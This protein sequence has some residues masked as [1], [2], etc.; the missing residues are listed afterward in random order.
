MKFQKKQNKQKKTQ[1]FF[2]LICGLPQSF[3][4]LD[5]MLFWP[6]N[7]MGQ[8]KYFDKNRFI[9]PWVSFQL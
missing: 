9:F 5:P 3:L 2:F 4:N 6:L 8:I 1:E 7:P